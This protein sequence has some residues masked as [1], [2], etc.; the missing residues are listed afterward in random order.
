VSTTVRLRSMSLAVLFHNM[1]IVHSDRMLR[2]RGSSVGVVIRLSTDWKAEEPGLNFRQGQEIFLI[3]IMPI[4]VLRPTQSSIQWVSGAVSQ[5]V[6]RPGREADH[7][8][9]YSAEVKNCGAISPLPRT[10]SWRGAQ[11]I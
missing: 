5:E 7:A 8:H 9:P 11:L 1:L 2:N 3:S 6:K 10:S 4:P